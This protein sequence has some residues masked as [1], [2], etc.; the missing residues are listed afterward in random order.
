[1]Q[2]MIAHE[3]QQ[4]LQSVEAGKI[5]AFGRSYS[6]RTKVWNMLAMLNLQKNTTCL[7]G[8]DFNW[9]GAQI[10]GCV[11]IHFLFALIW[12]I[13]IRFFQH[14]IHV[15]DLPTRHRQLQLPLKIRTYQWVNGNPSLGP[16][17]RMDLIWP[18]NMRWLFLDQRLNQV[19]W[20]RVWFPFLDFFGVG[21]YS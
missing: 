3:V 18:C 2:P 6:C 7:W 13:C 21:R 16:L 15:F 12:F 4:Q 9:W 11:M 8:V 17:A 14:S 19:T 5:L 20:L 1:M 10:F